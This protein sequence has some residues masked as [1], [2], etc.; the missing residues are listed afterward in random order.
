MHKFVVLVGFQKTFRVDSYDVLHQEE[1]N[2]TIVSKFEF[3]TRH[4]WSQ[5]P[6]FASEMR[7]AFKKH[8]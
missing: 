2:E 5:N 4:Y 8:N 6:G 3:A 7:C 1:K